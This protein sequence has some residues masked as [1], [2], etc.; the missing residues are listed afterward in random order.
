MET[1]RYKSGLD[2]FNYRLDGSPSTTRL[3]KGLS[4]KNDLKLF[5][6]H[7]CF[8]NEPNKLLS[9]L[10]ITDKFCKAHKDRIGNLK[11]D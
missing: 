7:D 6:M 9:N 4:F 10:F 2:I 1:Y 5:P 8:I 11:N 3:K